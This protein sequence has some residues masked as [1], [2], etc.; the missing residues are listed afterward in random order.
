MEFGSVVAPA[1]GC[2]D[3]AKEKAEMTAYGQM[4]LAEYNHPKFISIAYRPLMGDEFCSS[5]ARFHGKYSFR[6]SLWCF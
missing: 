2:A 1:D 5:P 6:H 4:S 3:S